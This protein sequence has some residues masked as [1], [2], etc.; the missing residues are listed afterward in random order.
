MTIVFCISAI[1]PLA[2]FWLWPQSRIL[3]SEM[4]NAEERHSVIATN[5]ATSLNRY[6]LDVVK[7]F[8]YFVDDFASVNNT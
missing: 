7:T 8:N 3:D 6:Y 2:I 4:K 5:L 1:A